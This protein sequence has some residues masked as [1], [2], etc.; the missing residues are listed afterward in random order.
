MIIEFDSDYDLSA[1]TLKKSDFLMNKYCGQ[2][3]AAPTTSAYPY[4][5]KAG[6]RHELKSLSKKIHTALNNKTIEYFSE[7]EKFKNLTLPSEYNKLVRKNT[8][9]SDQYPVIRVD[10]FLGPEQNSIE[11]LEL[12]CA[13]PSAFAW[14]DI[15]VQAL[16]QSDFYQIFVKKISKNIHVDFLI[17]KYIEMMKNNFSEFCNIKKYGE[18]NNFIH[19]YMPSDSSV[20]F[21]FLCLKF[22]LEQIG[23]TVTL[24]ST[25]S[26]I[27]DKNAIHIRDSFEDLF[28]SDNNR[29]TQKLTEAIISQD[30]FM[31]NPSS[32]IVGDQKSLLPYMQGELPILPCF[33]FNSESGDFS[34]VISN[35]D[36]Y[37]L[38]PS[39]G[40]GGYGILVGHKTDHRE[41]TNL[42]EKI[43]SKNLSYIGQIYRQ[44]D[45]FVTLTGQTVMSNFN[46]WIF[47]GRFAGAFART[48]ATEPINYHQG[49]ALLPVVYL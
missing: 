33:H 35:K 30:Y 37:V 48:S 24:Q 34:E 39:Q 44:P 12:N 1:E 2:F 26:F 36:K 27:D 21:D 42:I 47:G 6:L 43:C 7:P 11:I 22:Q 32:S 40:Y 10:C 3:G 45:S 38:K 8:I 28:L 25:E 49:G 4:F 20:Y 13:E 19:L 23:Y 14:N 29:K 9:F 17:P 41:W 31:L 46:F 15:M 5:C 16:L 18:F